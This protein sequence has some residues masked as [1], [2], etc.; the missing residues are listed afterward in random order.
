MVSVYVVGL[1][2]IAGT[3]SRR[4]RAPSVT[5]SSVS[6]LEVFAA[7][8][9][10]IATLAMV[11]T[12]G[13]PVLVAAAQPPG[14]GGDQARMGVAAVRVMMVGD[15]ATTGLAPNTHLPGLKGGSASY[16]RRLEALVSDALRPQ[17]ASVD[18]DGTQPTTADVVFVGPATA[19]YLQ[20]HNEKRSPLW[21]GRYAGGWSLTAEEAATMQLVPGWIAKWRP[22]VVVIQLGGNDLGRAI[23]DVAGGSEKAGGRAA[24][25]V[26]WR[27]KNSIVDSHS[28]A[29]GVVEDATSPSRQSDP[30]D[31][32]GVDDIDAEE[33]VPWVARTVA[34]VA[35]QAADALAA[36]PGRCVGGEVIVLGLLPVDERRHLHADFVADVNT[37]IANQLDSARP[38]DA[39]AVGGG[40]DDAGGKCAVRVRFVNPS[41]AL[42]PASEYM[43]A[44]AG[45]VP[46]VK[47]EERLAEL[48]A[49]V[50]AAAVRRTGP[51]VMAAASARDASWVSQFRL[52]I[53]SGKHIGIGFVVSLCTGLIMYSVLRIVAARRS[54]RARDDKS[55]RVASTDL[56]R[57]ILTHRRKERARRLATLQTVPSASPSDSI[58]RLSRTLPPSSTVSSQASRTASR[59]RSE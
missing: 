51:S 58:Q 54:Y 12:N 24:Q 32:G 7:A 55:R 50:V 2:S 36:P 43:A 8:A 9:A 59:S 3:L 22:N 19:P 35:R 33:I 31:D 20:G 56:A 23:A 39:G 47:G 40:D 5:A 26:S 16:R 42:Q 53:P 27:Q 17:P 57:A 4:M 15:H 38:A 52:V 25:G 37:H 18:E 45:Y 41:D 11:F 10:C 13:P 30:G 21:A 44:P 49:P 28:L 34:L 6:R 46:N 48:L 14:F 29:N 1:G